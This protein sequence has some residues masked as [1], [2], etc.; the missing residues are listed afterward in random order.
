[1]KK[2]CDEPW[3]QYSNDHPGQVHPETYIFGRVKNSFIRHRSDKKYPE[4][5]AE[6]TVNCKKDIELYPGTVVIMLKQDQ[7]GKK[8]KDYEYYKEDYHL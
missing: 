3:Y 6:G 4:P 1:M 5:D 2:R 8:F 7:K